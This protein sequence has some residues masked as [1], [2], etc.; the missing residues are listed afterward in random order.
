MGVGPGSPFPSKARPKFDV[1]V[2]LSS[3]LIVDMTATS[4]W[5]VVAAI[6]PYSMAVAFT[7]GGQAKCPIT[8]DGDRAA[9]PLI[10]TTVL[11][12]FGASAILPYVRGERMIASQ[13]KQGN[14]IRR[15]HYS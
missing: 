1:S 14:S 10:R 6:M 9:D 13:S 12:A 15:R 8:V 2:P 7:D 11:R 5:P 3:F 4:A